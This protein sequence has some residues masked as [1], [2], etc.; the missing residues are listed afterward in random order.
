MMK[1]TGLGHEKAMSPE[2]ACAR[3]ESSSME[4]PGRRASAGCRRGVLSGIVVCDGESPLHGE[5]PDGSTQ[6][7]KE[8]RAGHAGSGKHEPTSLRAIATRA[9]ESKH[10]RFRNLYREVNAELLMHCWHGLNKDAAS[11]VDQLTAETY[12][13]NLEGNI[14]DLAERVKA[15]RYRAKLVRRVYIPKENG[16]ERPL[17]IPTVRA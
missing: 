16:K 11:G 17:G 12:A 1:P 9:K 2:T 6:P 5:G 14:T 8:T 4:Q 3:V 10:H 15:G 13:A 7:V